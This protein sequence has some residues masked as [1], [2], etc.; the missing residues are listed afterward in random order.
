MNKSPTFCILPWIHAATH[1]D[2]AAILCCVSKTSNLNLNKHSWK[3]VWNSE[4]FK[5]AR[6]SMLAGEQFRAC[7]SCWKEES[8]GI[9][10]HRQYENAHWERELGNDHIEKLIEGTNED[11]SVSHDLITVDFRLGNTCNLQCIMCRPTDSSKW[12]K[13]A[14]ELADTAVTDLKYDWKYK[15]NNFSVEKFEWYKNQE[16]W[17]SF[18]ES[19]GDI[20]HIIFGGGEPLLIKEHKQ[21]IKDLVDKGHAKNIGIRYHT[22]GTIYDNELVALWAEFKV[23][24]VMISIDGYNEIND[25]IRYPSKW[26]EIVEVL[27][28]YD[29]TGDNIDAKVLCTVQAANIYYLPEFADWMLAQNFKK[30][31]KRWHSGIFHDGILHFPQYLCTKVLPLE[32]KERVT[33]KIIDY[34]DAH[35]DNRQIQKFRQLVEFMNSED[36]SDKFT[37]T[38]EYIDKLDSMRSTDSKFFRDMID[39]T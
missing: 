7:E 18:M 23:V 34:C 14:K 39:G 15:M 12:V 11:G 27:R 17:D 6:V 36:W 16:F 30:L 2:G 37:Q 9:K 21:L 26:D 19:S 20:K 5:S 13:H 4:H 33:K 10:S 29:N 22:N 24:E 32:T 8:A 35:Q 3:D 38:L 31:G 1:T 28:L 25:Y